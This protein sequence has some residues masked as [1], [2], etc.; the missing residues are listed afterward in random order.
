MRDFNDRRVRNSKTLLLKKV[1]K[2]RNGGNGRRETLRRGIRGI[3]RLLAGILVLAGVVAGTRALLTLRYFDVKEITIVGN[4]HLPEEAI[5]RY[6]KRLQ[7]NIFLLRLGEVRK[8]LLAEPYVK[9]AFLR[10][11]LPDKVYL[12]IRERVPFAILRVRRRERLID[13]EGRILEAPRQPAEKA[14]PVIEGEEKVK[15]RKRDL[16]AALQLVETIESY[17]YPDLAEIDAVEMT[18]NKGMVLRPV[19]GKFDI[20]CGRGDYLQKM[21]RLKRVVEDLATRRWPVRSIDLRFQDQ[22]VVR[23]RKAVRVAKSVAS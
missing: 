2:Q 20:C 11:E 12:R 21:I 18:K 23:T 22:V 14:L 1:R 16:L 7:K 8:D 10:R 13:R 17:G 5:R 3:G 4:V 9:D 19:S 15:V 6:E